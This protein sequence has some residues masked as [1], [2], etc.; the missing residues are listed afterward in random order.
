[1]IYSWC[2]GKKNKYYDKIKGNEWLFW[3][4]KK[5]WNG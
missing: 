5:R 3:G 1:M 4:G 2:K